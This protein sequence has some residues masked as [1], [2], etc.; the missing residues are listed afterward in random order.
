[1]R[2]GV[3]S[4]L[5]AGRGGRDATRVAELL[6][7]RPDVL[8]VYTDRTSDLG[9]AIADLLNREIDV[10]VIHG[11]DGTVQCAL[12]ELLRDPSRPHLPALAPLRGGRTNMTSTDLGADRDPARGLARLLAAAD[13]GE[14]EPLAVA[15][16]VLRVR[17]AR[18]EV[19]QYGMFFGAG[20]IYRA[21]R[22]VHRAFSGNNQGLL[23]AGLVTGA[24]VARALFH[25]TSGILTPDKCQVRGDGRDLTDAELYLLISTTLEK[26]FLRMDPFWGPGA[27]DVR[28]TAIA[29]RAH[30][31]ALAAPGILSGR[32]PPWLAPEL[33]YVSERLERA[34]LRIGCGFTVDGELF[35]PETEEA[36]EISADRRITFL[37]A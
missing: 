5:R 18:R 33:G 10:L 4:N 36:I 29:S 25:P 35:A 9:P 27:G 22:L 14:I 23:G 37:R 16:P 11:G 3:L 12:T 8:S 17:S 28:L 1:M 7:S 6:N 26:L 15:R 30:R 13:A 19:D 21:I 32:A 24:L 34:E 20:L 2:I 31:M